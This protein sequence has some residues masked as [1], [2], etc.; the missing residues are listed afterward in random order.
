MRALLAWQGGRVAPD[1]NSTL[2]VTF[3]RV[4]GVEARDGLFFLPQTRLQ[5]IVEKHT[6]EGEFNAP[7]RL[8]AAIAA[9]H[10]GKRSPYF[11][12]KLGDVPVDFLADV[13]T[14]G[15]N[16][17][18]AALNSKGELVGLLFD[19]TYGTVASDFL[20][21]TERT[22][23]ILVD[24]RCLLWTWAEVEGADH[25]LAEVGLR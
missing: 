23:S 12:A 20:Y 17:G 21:D 6:G 25:L 13:D 14:T 19:G 16:S 7:P 9:L 24:S 22:R 3:G 4:Q 10:A 1:A 8:L 15:G 11:D 18:S 5:G 2:R